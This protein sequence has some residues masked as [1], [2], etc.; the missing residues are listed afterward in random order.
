MKK[1]LKNEIE[2]L[3]E[4]FKVMRGVDKGEETKRPY[5][6]LIKARRKERPDFNTWV[7]KIWIN[8]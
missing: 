8:H 6:A 7:N 5:K 2:A 4:L 1:E 3:R